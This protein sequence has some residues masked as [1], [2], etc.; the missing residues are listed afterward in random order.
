[1]ALLGI[2][3]LGWLGV[4]YAG[5]EMG[6]FNPYVTTGPRISP[7]T[8]SPTLRKWYLPQTL[9]YLYGWKGW[10]YTNYARNNYGRYVDI[11]M[12]GKRFYD[13]YGNYIAKGWNVYN[14]NQQYPRDL[15][16]SIFKHPNFGRWFDRLLISSSS[17]GQYHMALTVG[18]AIRTTLTPLTFSK[19]LFD[20]LQWD[21]LADKYAF[22]ILASRADNTAEVA[23]AADQGS[24]S[25][26]TFTQLLGFRG[27]IGIG[28]FA[29]V[30][31]TYV[32]ASHQNSELSM[33]D[34]SL[35]GVLSGDMNTGGGG[36]VRKIMVRL[37]DD[38]PEDGKGGA[39]LLRQRVFIDGVE[40]HEIEP[41]V[42]GGVTRMGLLEASGG[43]IV[44]LTYD[45]QNDFRSGVEDQITDFKEIRKIE[46]GLVLANDY[47]VEAAS[48]MQTNATGEPA[49]LLVARASGNI[50]DASNQKYIRF[51]YGVPTGNE[52][53]GITLELTDVGGFNF[54]GEYAVNRRFRRF[55]NQNIRK[56]QALATD[57]SEAIYATASQSIYPWFAYGEIFSMDPEYSTS[58]FIPDGRGFVDYENEKTYLYEFV[59][60]N[61]DQDR[62]PDWSRR[63]TGVYSGDLPDRQVFPGLDENND[64]I[65]DFNQNGNN[66]PDYA[67]PFLRY[68]VDPPE[69]LFGAD[70]NNNTVIDRFENDT[71]PDY[72][73]KRDHRGYNIYTGVEIT[74]GSRL[75]IGHLNEHLISS[76]RKNRST[77]GLLTLHKD[78]PR[79]HLDLRF[80]EFVRSVRDNIPDHLIQWVQPPFSSGGLQ[81]FSDPLIT[82]RT[83]IHTMYLEINYS[84]FLPFKNKF[85]YETYHQRGDQAEGKRDEKFFGIINKADYRIPIGGSLYFWPKWKQLFQ[86]R[87]PT[88]PRTLRTKERSEIFSL[89]IR[90]QFSRQL[91]IHSGVEYE[92]FNNLQGKPDPPPPGYVDDFG[93]R[94][95]AFQL[96]NT[97]DYLG[98]RLT[99]NAGIRRT[100]RSFEKESE[101]NTVAFVSVFVGSEE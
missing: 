83:L 85:K 64:L 40:H 77:Y 48:N 60:D 44:T 59:E 80:M 28:D 53:G 18:E 26:T 5:I 57:R 95:L 41:L 92:I 8:L 90:Y 49:Y 75:M 21:F 25:R 6:F 74:P 4:S 96:S 23:I 67:E 56:N 20:G 99:S 30:G 51:Q 15:G 1:M 94:T 14:W 87:R 38:S 16:S 37:S 89:L 63:Y 100:R 69:F 17:K 39:L 27:A 58:M 91:W 22:T 101:T 52:V 10:E 78:F 73:Y 29:K 11:E 7:E 98:Y 46:V 50:T 3:L 45:I 31:L 70:M 93:K 54:K 88:N 65:S 66:Q 42:E 43:D 86:Y 76:D 55:P 84:E 19:P 9:Y 33:D 81:D 68:D 36:N 61:D 13:I 97:C 24:T 34:N 12:E 82:Q 32:D 79:Q 2:V 47:R 72:P 35:K 71:E 62:Y